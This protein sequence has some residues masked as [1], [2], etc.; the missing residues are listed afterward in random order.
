[1]MRFTYTFIHN[2]HV[3]TRFYQEH[4]FKLKLKFSFLCQLEVYGDKC[5][6][7]AKNQDHK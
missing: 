3:K 4:N 5:A 2:D 1:M 7:S 6:M